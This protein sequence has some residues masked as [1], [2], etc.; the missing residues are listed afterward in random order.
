MWLWY[1]NWGVS[2][3][4]CSGHQTADTSG[5]QTVAIFLWKLNAVAGRRW[6]KTSSTT[7][8]RTTPP[9]PTT[10]TRTITKPARTRSEKVL[11]KAKRSRRE[12][13]VSRQTQAGPVKPRR[14]HQAV[15]ESSRKTFAN[16]QFNLGIRLRWVPLV[17]YFPHILTQSLQLQV[18]EERRYRNQLV[19]HP[20]CLR[21]N[22][23]VVSHFGLFT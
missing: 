19:I 21:E 12:P 6:L 1:V 17:P 20:S 10:T 22:S 11:E 5:H 23:V 8:S 14:S 15:V 2:L 9:P 13:L 4:I 18:K 7:T 3:Q 16:K